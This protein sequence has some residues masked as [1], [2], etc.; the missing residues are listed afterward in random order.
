M[1]I[2]FKVF[3]KTAEEGTF[4]N[5]SFAAR[6]TLTPKPDKDTTKKKIIDHYH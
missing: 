5:L 4:L 6:I 3:Q 1:L 2:H